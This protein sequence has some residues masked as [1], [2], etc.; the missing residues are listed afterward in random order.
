MIGGTKPSELIAYA[1]EILNYSSGKKFTLKNNTSWKINQ[2]PG[3]IQIVSYPGFN[4]EDSV[5]T[6]SDIKKSVSSEVSENSSE[7]SSP[8]SEGKIIMPYISSY[9]SCSHR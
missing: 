7:L 9:N 3:T 2:R 5:S 1:A 8:L 6:T 4:F